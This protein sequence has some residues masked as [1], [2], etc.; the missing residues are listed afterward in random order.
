MTFRQLKRK[1]KSVPLIGKIYDFVYGRRKTQRILKQREEMFSNNAGLKI[2]S[3][4]SNLLHKEEIVSFPDF[5]TLLGIVRDGRLLSWDNDI[6]F[7]IIMN[8]STEWNNLKNIL[9]KNN[10]T[11]I[12][13]FKYDDEIFEQTYL[14][15]NM[16]I[17]FFRHV[18]MDYYCKYYTFS[19]DKKMNDPTVLYDIVESRT[20]K[21]TELKNKYVNSFEFFIPSNSEVFLAD[22]YGENWRIP[23]P[24]FSN[25]TSPARYG[26]IGNTGIKEIF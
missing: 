18:N 9:E 16:S 22:I 19:Q 17:D 7:G 1:V 6:D 3:T 26:I 2:V 14:Y 10:F 13:Q 11:L 5:G 21:I 24:K 8:D 15:E 12:H 20:V 23:D 25:G 4:I